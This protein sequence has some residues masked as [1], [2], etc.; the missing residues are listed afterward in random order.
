M[1]GN[2]RAEGRATIRPTRPAGCKNITT[3]EKP[4]GGKNKASHQE[5]SARNV[6]KFDKTTQLM[7]VWSNYVLYLYKAFA[8]EKSYKTVTLHDMK[9]AH[10]L[11]PH[12]I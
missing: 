3:D 5:E 8:A 1:T 2:G 7:L 6:Q 12:F 9:L 10:K 4:A 11:H